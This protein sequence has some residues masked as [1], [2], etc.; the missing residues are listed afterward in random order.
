LI[1][2]DYYSL[3]FLHLKGSACLALSNVVNYY[4]PIIDLIVDTVDFFVVLMIL[5]AY[6][7]AFEVV[8]EGWVLTIGLNFELLVREI[9]ENDAKCIECKA[10][11]S[12]IDSE[13][14]GVA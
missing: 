1:S 8:L 14:L 7:L 5:T 12:H 3:A 4:F 6:S 11:N 10:Y 9:E 2:A 13:L